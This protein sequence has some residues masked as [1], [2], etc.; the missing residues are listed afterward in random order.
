MGWFVILI[1]ILESSH[2]NRKTLIQ[3]LLGWLVIYLLVR[4]VELNICTLMTNIAAPLVQTA[5][6]FPISFLLATIA[7]ID[8]ITT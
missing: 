3:L 1:F 7:I 2:L 6:V 4:H 8:A 5:Q